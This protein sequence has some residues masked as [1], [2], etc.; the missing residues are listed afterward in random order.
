MVSAVGVRPT[1]LE[2]LGVLMSSLDQVDV[3][4]QEKMTEMY[5][6]ILHLV[7]LGGQLGSFEIHFSTSIRLGTKFP[8]LL[9]EILSFGLQITILLHLLTNMVVIVFVLVLSFESL[10]TTHLVLLVT[11]KRA[12]FGR[13]FLG[14]VDL[15]L[16][17]EDICLKLGLGV[18][19]IV[20]PHGRRAMRTS[21]I[22]LTVRSRAF[23]FRCL[24]RSRSL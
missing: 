21:S 9:I 20:I 5:E 14:S 15:S 12:E 19:I 8:Q 10:E 24:C 6:R 11:K 22:K 13:E 7:R 16:G 4:S 1:T 17:T 18:T 3:I 2:N 23:S